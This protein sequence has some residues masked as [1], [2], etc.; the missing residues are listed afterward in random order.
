MSVR[1]TYNLVINKTKR[2]KLYQ[3]VF[4]NST[5][6]SDFDCFS[7]FFKVDS[8]VLKYLEDWDYYPEPEWPRKDVWSQLTPDGR[9]KIGCIYVVERAVSES[10]IEITFLPSCWDISW[11]FRDSLSVREWFIELS[12]MI[13]ATMTFLKLEN[14]GH[15]ILYYKGELIDVGLKGERHLEL[16]ASKF[17]EVMTS[18]AKYCGQFHSHSDTNEEDE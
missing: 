11:L 17:V 7:L 2:E 6:E 15:R 10:E 18:F 8:H 12:E 13:S 9:A 4:A 3:Y 16:G 5:P 1:H 14:E